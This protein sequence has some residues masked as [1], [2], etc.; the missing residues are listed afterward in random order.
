MK[1][2]KLV[3][4]LATAA[5]LASC[6]GG[7]GDTG[8]SSGLDGLD[9]TGV[10]D[11]SVSYV[12]PNGAGAQDG[13]SWGNCYSIHN[14]NTAI[15]S[16]ARKQGEVWF[17]SGTYDFLSK[18]KWGSKPA[19][20]KALSG[21]KLYGSFSGSETN[22]D[23]RNIKAN[24][25]IID[26]QKEHQVIYLKDVKNVAIDGFTF[27]NIYSDHE[28]INAENSTFS[29]KNSVFTSLEKGQAM[30]AEKSIIT[31][32]NIDVKDNQKMHSCTLNIGNSKLEIT[33]SR[34]NNN[35][36][37]DKG[38]GICALSSY[39][40]I[41]DSNFTNNVSG[42][43]G[44]VVSVQNTDLTVRGSIFDNNSLPNQHIGSA[45]NSS[46]GNIS[47]TAKF[48]HSNILIDNSKFTNNSNRAIS[49]ENEPYDAD[50]SILKITNSLFDG[51]KKLS[52][53]QKG[54]AIYVNNSIT[55][56]KDSNFTNN[57]ASEYGGAINDE[58]KRSSYENVI[59]KNNQASSKGGAL[60]LFRSKSVETNANLKNVLFESNKAENAGAIYVGD[61][62]V[63]KVTNASFINNQAK[64]SQD[65]YEISGGAIA[66][67]N[68][69]K[70]T[71]I[72]ST[73]SGNKAINDGSGSS[74]GGA[75]SSTDS[76]SEISLIN[77]TITNNTA[78]KG[79]AI[80][81]HDEGKTI[82]KNSIIYGN[83]SSE[84]GTDVV[85]DRK[86]GNTVMYIDNSI[87]ATPTLISKPNGDTYSIPTNNINSSNP[88]LGTRQSKEVN[89]VTQYYYNPTGSNVFS[90]GN[91]SFNTETTDQIGNARKTSGK[92]DIGSIQSS[93]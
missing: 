39:L 74:W 72:N 32:D 38:S 78:K 21:V 89:G 26:A 44:G 19:Y 70:A 35:K 88:T 69:V 10:P 83:T 14:V 30:A 82:I 90:K 42:N 16:V 50:K 93:N 18:S 41:V 54:G 58:S 66:N 49:V 37:K 27:K 80:Y 64:G 81:G 52:T 75:I 25:S 40:T 79:G 77:T 73:F 13:S 71:F 56:I 76:R 43:Q 15:K 1:I 9:F 65:M 53:G 46:R 11:R 48:E 85:N 5:F 55:E 8:G 24:P 23:D 61:D 34:F 3:L 67:E 91:P 57:I 28:A 33:N 63:L 87:M 12:C 86:Y 2:F 59:F 84:G 68:D 60:N 22:K 7:G 20:F 47:N 62:L 4:P 29:L 36:T 31:I 51:N 6:G 92:I 45:I 17:K